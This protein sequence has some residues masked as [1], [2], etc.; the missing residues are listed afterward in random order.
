MCCVNDLLPITRRVLELVQ[1]WSSKHTGVLFAYRIRQCHQLS[2]F[3]RQ[4][5][6]IA[7]ALQKAVGYR[8]YNTSSSNI[9][10]RVP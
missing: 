3:F 4:L 7:Y 9:E 8:R 5:D 2:K 6:V 10:Y 1:R